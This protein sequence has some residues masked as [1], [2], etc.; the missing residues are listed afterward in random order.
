MARAKVYSQTAS[1]RKTPQNQPIPG[2]GQVANNAGGFGWKLDKWAQLYRFLILG[3]EKGTYY[4]NERDLTK[5]NLDAVRACIAEDGLRVVQT[6]TQVSVD[7]LAVKQDPALVV[8]AMCA[9]DKTQVGVRKAAL[10]ALPQ[11]ARTGTALFT[12]IEYVTSMRGWGRM[13]VRAVQ[14]WYNNKP[15][16]D[17]AYQLMK[18]QQR[19]GWAQRDVLRLAHPSPET[20]DHNLIFRH[21]VKGDALALNSLRHIP[22]MDGIYQLRELAAGGDPDVKKSAEIITK[23]KLP[24][25]VIPTELLAKGETWAALLPNM[26]MTALLRNLGN[27]AKYGVVADGKWSE[28]ELV[29]KKL[30]DP[31]SLHKARVHPLAVLIGARTYAQ[32]HGFRGSGSWTPVAQ[33]MKALDTAFYEAFKHVEPTGKRYLVGLDISGSMSSGLMNFPIT[34]AEAAAAL[35][36]VWMRTEPKTII[37]GFAHEFR[38][39]GLHAGMSLTDVLLRTERQTFGGTDCALPMQFALA[40]RIEVDQFVVITDNETWAGGQHPSQA[41][42]EYRQQS[43]INAKL[44]VVGMCSND[45]SIADPNDAGM[46]DFAGFDSSLPDAI[47]AFARS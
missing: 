47:A 45:I 16:S 26:P 25:E 46:M 12:F 13:L 9:S 43:G 44:A 39:L 15:A 2:S 14:G 29:V 7:G 34:V 22:L 41:L 38:D 33:V 18:Y 3:S 42:V 11:V 40:N 36:M 19:E 10:R 5:S 20:P 24:R 6:A 4:V 17:V 37:R 23:Y 1:T 30:T 21:V 28:I 32:G 31:D 35:G 27:L 8:L